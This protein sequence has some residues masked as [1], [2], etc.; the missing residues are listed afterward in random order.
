[1]L[2]ATL[3]QAQTADSVVVKK[4]YD[5]T[6]SHGQ[7]Y[8]WLRQLT[9]QI[10]GRLAGSANAAKLYNGAKVYSNRLVQIV[11]SYKM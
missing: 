4:L 9:T 3:S 6:L 8:E 2:S 10:G 11:F 1:L 5:A 7:S